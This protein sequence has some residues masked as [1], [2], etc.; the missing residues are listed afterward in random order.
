MY[1]V[2][3]DVCGEHEK[4]VAEFNTHL[5]AT[6]YMR[7]NYT[8]EERASGFVDIAKTSKED[9]GMITFDF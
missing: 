5:A 2:V 3:E 4:V 9:E 1:Y 6:E 8:L 7:A